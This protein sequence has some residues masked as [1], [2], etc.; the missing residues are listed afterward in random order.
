MASL[1]SEYTNEIYEIEK[2]KIAKTYL[3]YLK[4]TNPAM[5]NLVNDADPDNMIEEI[6]YLLLALTEYLSSDKYKYLFLNIPSLSMDSLRKFVYYLIDIFKSYT[7]DLKAMN[8]IYH[9]DDKRIH[10]IKLI[11]HEDNFKKIW[12]DYDKI[13]YVDLIE[14]TFTKFAEY[15]R[16]K[17]LFKENFNFEFTYEELSLLFKTYRIILSQIDEKRGCVIKDF[18]DYFSK[19]DKKFEIEKT[20]KIADEILY[21][22]MIPLIDKFILKDNISEEA[23]L[24]KF[25]T[26]KFKEF[27]KEEVNVELFDKIV[28]LDMCEIFKINGWL[29]EPEYIKLIEKIKSNKT[30]ISSKGLLGDHCDFIEFGNSIIDKNNKMNIRDKYHFIRNE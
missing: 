6:D 4:H 24:D 18:S 22:K 29:N 11:L 13:K 26:I 3:E 9:I 2:G 10:N 14:T 30:T 19:M 5:Y 21:N 27:L 28:L 12:C 8:I 25:D 16:I 23:S 17:M 7:V 15:D 1:Y 20:I